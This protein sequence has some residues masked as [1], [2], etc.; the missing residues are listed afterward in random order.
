M[1]TDDSAALA[2]MNSDRELNQRAIRL[3][4]YDSAQDVADESQNQVPIKDG[5]LRGSLFIEGEGTDM[6]KVGYGGASAPYA[7]RQHEELDWEH[8]GGGKA[9]YLQDPFEQELIEWRLGK[10]D[11]LLSNARIR[12]GGVGV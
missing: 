10:L 11:R 6:V 9:K 2:A 7:L 1:P 8:P 12:L 3:A 4:I 5:I